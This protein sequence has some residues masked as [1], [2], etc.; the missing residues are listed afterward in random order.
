M[1]AVCCR[2]CV[3]GVVVEDVRRAVLIADVPS[4]VVESRVSGVL[5]VVVRLV[6]SR[7]G[8]GEGGAKC[9]LLASHNT[10]VYAGFVHLLCM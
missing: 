4:G 10:S 5:Y 9:L 6:R 2:R 3:N 8:L 1:A 7:V